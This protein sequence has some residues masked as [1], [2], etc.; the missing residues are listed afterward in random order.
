MRALVVCDSV[1][2]NTE[3]IARAVVEGL[4]EH[5]SVRLL[6]AGFAQASDLASID[7]LVLGGPT[8]RHHASDQLR[9][10]LDRLPGC[11][12]T[13]VSAAAFDTRYRMS[14]FLTGSAA[15]DAVRVMRRA[16]AKLVDEPQ[17][18]FI[19]PDQP[20][21]GQRRRHEM[22]TFAPGEVER[23]RTW[24]AGLARVAAVKQPA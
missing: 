22:E 6:R 10:F 2:G 24:A 21:R 3:T 18:F 7:L 11:S 8:Q 23:A 14:M 12:L 4:K 19:L 5:H 20:P 17:S 16:G 1:Y 13:D 9:E 15:A